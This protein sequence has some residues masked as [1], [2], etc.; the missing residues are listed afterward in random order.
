MWFGLP[1][2]EEEGMDMMR[3]LAR[4]YLEVTEGYDRL[5]C[6]GSVVDGAILP[7]NSAEAGV[8]ARFSRRM[9]G[10]VNA[11]IRELGLDRQ[12]WARA[13]QIETQETK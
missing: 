8:S 5:V 11:V 3:Q 2:E 13:L 4:E 6:S 1:W 9:M 7:A 10:K 12:L